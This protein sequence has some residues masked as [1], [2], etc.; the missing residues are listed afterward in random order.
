MGLCQGRLSTALTPAWRRFPGNG[1]DTKI[2]VLAF[3]TYPYDGATRTAILDACNPETGTVDKICQ[4]NF[5]LG[6]LFAEAAKSIAA[7]AGIAIAD[8]DLIGSHGQT[9]YHLPN[10]QPFLCQAGIQSTLQIG[11]ASVIAQETGV[12]TVADFRPRDMAPEGKAPPRPLCGLYSV[13]EQGKRARAAEYRWYCK[14][15]LYTEG[16]RH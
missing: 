12:M 1:V 15:H 9:I 2:H 16:R 5:Y 4:L 10:A 7:R 3:D 13:S 11:E 14:R 8:V 6:K